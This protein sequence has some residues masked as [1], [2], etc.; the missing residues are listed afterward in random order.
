MGSIEVDASIHRLAFTNKTTKWTRKAFC[1]LLKLCCHNA[2][3]LLTYHQGTT[4][5]S[6]LILSNSLLADYDSCLRMFIE[7]LCRQLAELRDFTNTPLHKA[8][9]FHCR[10]VW[11]QEHAEL[12]AEKKENAKLRAQIAKMTAEKEKMERELAQAME[13]LRAIPHAWVAKLG[14][15]K[16]YN[17]SH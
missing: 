13:K 17:V 2:W 3:K 4:L 11:K 1:F 10:T 6:P 7:K 9:A 12:K 16:V 5:F 15:M 8:P 14:G